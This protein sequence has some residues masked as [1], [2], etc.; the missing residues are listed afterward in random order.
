[1]SRPDA[2]SL[3]TYNLRFPGQYFD[4]ETALRYNDFRYY[5][6]QGGRYTTSDPIG[7]TGGLNTYE[8]VSSNPLSLIDPTGLDWIEYTGQSV[9]YYGGSLGDRSNLVRS[10][11]A[12]SGGPSNQTPLDQ[13]LREVGPV[14][15]GQ[16]RVNLGP[17][18]TRIARTDPLTGAIYSN[19]EGGIEQIPESSTT[20]DGTEYT[21]PGW[22]TWRMRLDPVRG[23][24]FG[25]SNFYLHNSHKGYTHGCVETCDE[26]LKDVLGYRANGAL[27]ID[28]VIRYIT[29]TTNGGTKR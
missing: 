21:Y 4:D 27:S 9:S 24:T 6:A 1:M 23:N 22:G 15:A 29:P 19:P 28:V 10:C 13:R 14:P 11:P 18:P 25:R 16:Y 7:L 17:D 20:R 8:Y 3:F 26:L 2:Y 12:T 5:D